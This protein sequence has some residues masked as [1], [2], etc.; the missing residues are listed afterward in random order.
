MAADY[1]DSARIADMSDRR[2][3]RFLTGVSGLLLIGLAA[4]SNPA[5]EKPVAAPA[6]VAKAA[7]ARPA[8]AAPPEPAEPVMPD[9]LAGT[10]GAIETRS[11]DGF[12][13]QQILLNR[14]EL[15]GQ[16]PV[17]VR[18]LAH[19]LGLEVGREGGGAPLVF[20]QSKYPCLV[21]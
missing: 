17:R 16:R 10:F 7:P 20:R 12:R 2:R 9:G 19:E 13:M 18:C 5:A 6:P 4:C 3:S 8:P 14:P 21:M 11:A 1:A 15:D